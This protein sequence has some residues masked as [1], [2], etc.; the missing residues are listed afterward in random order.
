MKLVPRNGG[1][2]W[3]MKKFDKEDKREKKP[4]AMAF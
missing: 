3:R 1:F 4:F 2:W